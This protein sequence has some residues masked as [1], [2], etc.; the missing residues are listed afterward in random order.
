MIPVTRYRKQAIVDQ[1]EF[2]KSAEIVSAAGYGSNTL[3]RDGLGIGYRRA[4]ELIERLQVAG[5]LGIDLD[6]DARFTLLRPCGF[7]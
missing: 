1:T 4:A 6:E 2:A 5:V 7:Y 3:I